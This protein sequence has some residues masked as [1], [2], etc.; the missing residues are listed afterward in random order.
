MRNSFVRSKNKVFVAMIAISSWLLVNPA[1]SNEFAYDRV[2]HLKGTSN[3]RDIG[4][5]Q[6]G[7]LRT[8]RAGQ[9]I[10]SENLSQIGRAHV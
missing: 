10:R 3:T 7:D 4:G 9:I 1:F 6:T 8:L 5:Y 2:I